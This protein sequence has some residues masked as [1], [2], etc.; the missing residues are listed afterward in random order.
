MRGVSALSSLG[1][2]HAVAEYDKAVYSILAAYRGM[3]KPTDGESYLLLRRHP[4]FAQMSFFRGLDCSALLW[5]LCDIVD[6]RWWIISSRQPGV[7]PYE[8]IT[9]NL[10]HRYGLFSKLSSAD[11]RAVRASEAAKRRMKLVD[12]LTAAPAPEASAPGLLFRRIISANSSAIDDAAKLLVRVVVGVLLSCVFHKSFEWR[13]RLSD[14]TDHQPDVDAFRN[15]SP[16]T[17]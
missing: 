10:Y 3:R 15:W 9:A 4:A 2:W 7:D 1:G 8:T 14:Y 5:L 13:F 12:L 6:P 11:C 16:V 17:C